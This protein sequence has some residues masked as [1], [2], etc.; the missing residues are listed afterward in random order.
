MRDRQQRSVYRMTLVKSWNMDEVEGYCEL[1]ELGAPDFIEI[2]AVTYC[3][4]SDAST[5][6]MENA[7]WHHEVCSYAES[8]STRLRAR[9]ISPTYSIATEHEHS[10]CV[11]LARED[12]FKIDGSWHT[13]IDYDKFNGHIQKYYATR[14]SDNEHKFTSLDYMAPTPAWAVY[15]VSACPHI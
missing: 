5:L 4:K 13:W 14:G 7:P 2:K 6:T 11:L 10:C 1:I 3:G 12:K 15:Q 9:G 8:I